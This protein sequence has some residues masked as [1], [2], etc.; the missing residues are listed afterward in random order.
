MAQY[1]I[2]NKKISQ[3]IRVNNLSAN[4]IKNASNRHN[5][6]IDNI[7]KI[8]DSKYLP[9]NCLKFKLSFPTISLEANLHIRLISLT[10]VNFLYS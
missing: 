5:K 7:L 4:S 8:N 2:I 3:I 1:T 10:S 9:K 6:T